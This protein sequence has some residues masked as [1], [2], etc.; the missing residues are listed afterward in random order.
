[1]QERPPL[2]IKGCARTNLTSASVEF[3]EARGMRLGTFP[4]RS[5]VQVVPKASATISV[6]A[7]CRQVLITLAVACRTVF[8][9]VSINKKSERYDA[10]LALDVSRQCGNQGCR[11]LDYAET[12]DP[13]SAI[14]YVGK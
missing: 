1:M 7:A 12:K 5:S 10:L 13:A 11:P 3:S 14:T 8:P 9:L 2:E 6:D 4:R